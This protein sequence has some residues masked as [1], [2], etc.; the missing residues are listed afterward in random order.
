METF[1]WSSLGC[2]LG[3]NQLMYLKINLKPAKQ[4]Q[5][6]NF[7]EDYFALF[8]IT[9]QQVLNCYNNLIETITEQSIYQL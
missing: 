4:N 6:I 3:S 5:L 9:A 2:G 1:D 7:L 8:Y